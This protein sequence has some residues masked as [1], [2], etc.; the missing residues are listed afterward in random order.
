MYK[1]VLREE[2]AESRKWYRIGNSGRI[3]KSNVGQ[4]D[5]DG[6]ADGDND[7]NTGTRHNPVDIDDNIVDNTIANFFSSKWNRT[8]TIGNNASVS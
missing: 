4:K 7:N 3:D 8:E 2:E 5:D 1:D 6:E